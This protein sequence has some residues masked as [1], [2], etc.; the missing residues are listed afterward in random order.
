MKARRLDS[1]VDTRISYDLLESIFVVSSI[2]AVSVVVV[3]VV[4]AYLSPRKN[5]TKKLSRHWS[6]HLMTKKTTSMRT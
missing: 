5:W 2:A 6:F 1:S 4:V 3:V